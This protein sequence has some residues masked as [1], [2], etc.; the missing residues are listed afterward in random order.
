MIKVVC[1]CKKVQIEENVGRMLF[2]EKG[3][4]LCI[5]KGNCKESKR[6]LFC[7]I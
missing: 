6:H 5:E 1:K 2:H 4:E 7:F 3:T